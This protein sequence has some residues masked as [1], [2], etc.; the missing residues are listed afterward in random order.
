M[1]SE[2]SKGLKRKSL[3]V[4]HDEELDIK[5]LYVWFIQQGTS[6]TPISGPPDDL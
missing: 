1:Y 4:V 2:T 5:A 6:G 3:K